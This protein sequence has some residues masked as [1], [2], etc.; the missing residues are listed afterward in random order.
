VLFREKK[1][2]KGMIDNAPDRKKIS[3]TISSGWVQRANGQG[4]EENAI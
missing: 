4:S 2:G 1:G 3:P